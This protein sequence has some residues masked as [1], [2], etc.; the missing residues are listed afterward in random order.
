MHKQPWT[1]L[2]LLILTASLAS[3]SI[4]SIDPP[5]GDPDFTLTAQPDALSIAPG[6]SGTTSVRIARPSRPGGTVNLTLEGSMAGA[7]ADT[8]SGVFGAQSS[9]ASSLKL[10]VGTNVPAGTYPLSVRGT[11]GAITKTIGVQVKVE[12]WLLVD[13]DRSANNWAVTADHRPDPNVPASELDVLMK[14]A[15]DGKGFDVYAVKNADMSNTAAIAGPS[16]DVLKRYSGVVWYTGDQSYQHPI[17]SDLDNIRAYLD[18]GGRKMILLSPALVLNLPGAANVF[19]TTEDQPNDD[20][21]LQKHKAFL[22]DL[23]GAGG[24]NG[25][26]ARDAYTA[27]PLPG[28]AQQVGALSITG[29]QSQRAAFSP[30]QGELITG[31]YTAPVQNTRNEVSTGTVVIGRSGLGAHHNASAVFSGISPD[32]IASANK[33]DFLRLL[34]QD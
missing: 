19:Q 23:F 29:G 13:A 7:T 3:C 26:Y 30:Q 1:A 22:R 24:Y 8:I 9:G 33:L 21:S 14:S 18:E 31:L 20:A 28:K 11:N 32:V 6:Q 2:G 12:K 17:V 27:T 4:G 25:A 5:G 10:T 34:L 15:L 16:A